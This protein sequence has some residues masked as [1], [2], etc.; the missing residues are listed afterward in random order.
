MASKEDI[1]YFQEQQQKVP[2]N[3]MCFECKARNP[4]WCDVWHGVYIC[5]E[6]SGTHRSLGTHISFV[7]SLSMDTWPEDKMKLMKAGG[8]AKA[9][10]F[11]RSKGIADLPIRE[12]YATDA[13][14]MYKD[15]LFAEA[16]GKPFRESEWKPPERIRTPPPAPIN[17]R[18]EPG[19]GGSRYQGIAAPT[20]NQR[21]QS[22]VI[23]DAGAFLSKGFASLSSTLS[24]AASVAA[25]KSR[26]FAATQNV[27][28]KIAAL[29][30]K[31]KQG[32][33][34]LS[35]WLTTKA[36]G[37]DDDNPFGEVLA[38]VEVKRSQYTGISSEQ[39]KQQQQ[40]P[41]Q[42]GGS[43]MG[44]VPSSSPI[45]PQPSGSG[46]SRPASASASP[47]EDAGWSWGADEA[48]PSESPSDPRS[49]DSSTG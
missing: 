39:M 16:N 46:S 45:S 15:M 37:G 33:G 35:S 32:W 2:E 18:P 29:S 13:A 31:G 21:A 1:A 20:T 41:P 4:Q 25:S 3:K 34:S 10:A 23:G 6:C 24:D 48:Q 12:K 22:D 44:K 26:E 5:L 8:N 49:P 38:K 40:Q 28:E 19:F 42:R 47:K 43:P 27:G 7:R 9:L 36:S 17:A 14:A 30:D 11:F